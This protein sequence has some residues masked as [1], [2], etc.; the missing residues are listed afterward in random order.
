[1]QQGFLSTIS[2][3]SEKKFCFWNVHMVYMKLEECTAVHSLMGKKEEKK[4]LG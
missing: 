3:R 2:A 4:L 1:M